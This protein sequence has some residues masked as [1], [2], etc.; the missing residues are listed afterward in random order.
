MSNV[1]GSVSFIC[2]IVFIS[3]VTCYEVPSAIIEVVH[4]KGF[5]A[6]I[7]GEKG[8]TLF[9]FHGR[10][11]EEFEQTDEGQ[12]S[13][14]VLGPDPIGFWTYTNRE[15]HLKIG[16]V[17]HYWIYV[18]KDG[19]EYERVSLSYEVKGDLKKLTPTSFKLNLYWLNVLF[20]VNID[21][22]HDCLPYS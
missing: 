22:S 19:V 13:A 2:L 1:I 12:F 15:V 10:I 9:A 17:I 5:R 8:L 21:L 16:D 14:D 18:V 11:N 7:P 20:L 4:P 3:R 6:S